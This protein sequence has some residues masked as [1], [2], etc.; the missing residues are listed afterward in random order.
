MNK[1]LA[2]EQEKKEQENPIEMMKNMNVNASL[3]PYDKK[4]DKFREFG[5]QKQ[6]KPS[7]STK[8]DTF[9]RR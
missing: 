9:M 8:G 2:E 7:K 5:V 1:M 3:Y 4:V 6:E